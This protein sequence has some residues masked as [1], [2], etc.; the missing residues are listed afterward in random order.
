M[1]AAEA[2]I[3]LLAIRR[4]TDGGFIGY[5]GLTPG[6]ATLDEPE[7]AYELLRREWGNGYATEAAEA[8]IAAARATGRTRLWATIRSSNLRSLHVTEKL[9]F[10]RDH[11]SADA[12][13]DIVW[14][15]RTLG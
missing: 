12:R 14:M 7:L 8:V 15:T 2:G 4:R 11:S 1:R 13:G 5:C 6:R 3:A 10:H 9:G